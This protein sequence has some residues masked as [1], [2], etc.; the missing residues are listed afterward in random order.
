ML[1]VKMDSRNE[2]YVAVNRLS[3]AYLAENANLRS[4]IA[5]VKAKGKPGTWVD[6]LYHA[7]GGA[8]HKRAGFMVEGRRK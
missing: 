4:L 3:G 5:H 7:R 2:G 1:E 8:V 6:V